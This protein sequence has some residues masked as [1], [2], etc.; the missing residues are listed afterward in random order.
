MKI[1]NKAI[2]AVYL[3]LEK[4]G[5]YLLTRRCNTGYEDGKYHVPS[6]H[7]EDQELPTEAMIREAKEEIGI[8]LNAE[9]LE[10]VHLAYRPRHDPT[11]NRIDIFFRAKRWGGE[12]VNCE[13]EKC[14]DMQWIA[15]SDPPDNMT[16]Y[17]RNALQSMQQGIYSSEISLNQLKESGQYKL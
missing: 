1:R 17:V 5:K 7:V 4:D 16:Q 2:P 12:V 14:D 10:F 15:P 8:D 6:G 3:F 11:D 9:D 13:P